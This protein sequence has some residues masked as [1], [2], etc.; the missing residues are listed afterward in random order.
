[1][2]RVVLCAL[3][4]LAACHKGT[5]EVDAGAP[6]AGPAALTE[7][8]PNDRPEQALAITGSSIV[9]G[10]LS[11]DPSHPDE[12]W[13][14]LSANAPTTVDLSVS[15]IPGSDVVLEVDDADKNRLVT[16]NSAAEGKPERL[17]NL[18]L[19][20]TLL[21]KVSSA[22]RG[23]G[24]AYTL[25]AL[26]RPVT[27]G[28][29]SEPNDRAADSNLVPLG[30]SIS[31]YIGHANDEDWYRFEIAPETDAG[32][33]AAAPANEADAS[34]ATA[35][36]EPDAGAAPLVTWTADAGGAADGGTAIAAQAQDAGTQVAE[37]PGT[38]LKLQLTGVEGV[39]LEVQV[40]S[41][42]E[43]PLFSAKGSQEGEPLTLRNVGVRANDRVIYVVVKSAWAGPGKGEQRRGYNPD[44]PYTL[45][46]TQ[47]EAGAN[48]EMESNDDLQHATPLP[49]RGYRE[50]FL[51]PKT[52]VDYYV[53]R[54]DPPQTF[55]VQLSGVDRLDLVLSVVKPGENGGPEQT[56]MKVNDGAIKEPEY[57][58]DLFC[59]GECFLKV[60]GALKK[61]DGKW[62]R[63]Y[64]N[65]DLPYRLTV[66]PVQDMNSE[67]REPDNTPELATPI[68]LGKPVRG[69]IQPKR[70]VDYF[71]LDLSG[72]P[73]RTALR[74]TLLGVLKVDVALFLHRM[75]PDGKLEL[76]QTSNKA[77]GDQPEV[78]QYSAE[79]GVY[80][81]E[82]RDNKNR[83][84]NFQDSYQLTVEEGE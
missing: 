39:R 49:Q 35:G 66:T 67:E 58:N 64:D 11:A 27:P 50:G 55:N 21:V 1:M 32:T 26:F 10:Q 13:Y 54:A 45:T 62:V 48:A 4:A 83:E 33:E 29:E 56:L 30:E 3:V 7:K 78:I 72:R 6:D 8:E 76:V 15:G 63:E 82:V 57:L 20:A 51:S 37:A 79:P 31:G 16:V 34:T 28:V 22:K 23:A 59:A 14:R 68:A 19:R 5:E 71:K 36:G 18:G 53:L 60:E 69:T 84:S 24:G 17:P 77:K 41:A 52:D 43:A 25:T 70:D 12:D 80:L 44:K 9:T 42:A 65:A 46:V 75:G 38:A 61:Q 40:L 74:A 2:R 81:F 47:E 73:V